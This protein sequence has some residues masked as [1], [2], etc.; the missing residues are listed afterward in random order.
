MPDYKQSAHFYEHEGLARGQPPDQRGLEALTA[1]AD[2]REAR[3]A[4]GPQEARGAREQPPEEPVRKALERLGL[5]P[6]TK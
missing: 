6:H 4:R 3:G 2:K 5:S 1:A